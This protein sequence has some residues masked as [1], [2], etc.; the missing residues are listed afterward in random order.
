MKSNGNFFSLDGKSDVR[1]GV[2][3]VIVLEEEKRRAR[4]RLRKDTRGGVLYPLVGGLRFKATSPT[5]RNGEPP[6]CERAHER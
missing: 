1:P 4:E 6:L 5:H 2:Q 3:D